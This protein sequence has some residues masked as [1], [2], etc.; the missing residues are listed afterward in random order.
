VQGRLVLQRAW[1]LGHLVMSHSIH[2]VACLQHDSDMT[3]GWLR[4][5]WLAPRAHSGGLLSC[6]CCRCKET[7]EAKVILTTLCGHGHFDMSSYAKYLE[8][9]LKVRGGAG[10]SRTSAMS[11]TCTRCLCMCARLSTA[12]HR[13]CRPV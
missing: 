10:V 8:G 1:C 4:A 6:C 3:A 7:G 13:W 12:F 5:C 9:G 11:S 2:S